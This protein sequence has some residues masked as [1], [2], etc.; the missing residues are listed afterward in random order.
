LGLDDKKL[1]ELAQEVKKNAYA[2]YSKFAVGAALL[3]ESGNVYTGCNVENVSYGATICA[4]RVAIGKAVS[5]GHTKIKAIAITSNSV[6][7]IFP[8]GICRQVLTEFSDEN[9]KVLCTDRDGNISHFKLIEL[10]PHAFLK[11]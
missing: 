5:E 6:D 2:P 4:E 9:L 8:C 1:V 3:T 10:L 11:L 7:T